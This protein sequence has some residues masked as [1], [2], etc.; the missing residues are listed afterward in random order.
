MLYF[1]LEGAIPPDVAEL[2]SYILFKKGEETKIK[3]NINGTKTAQAW[4]S[5]NLFR[6]HS[7]FK[8]TYVDISAF[9]R[10]CNF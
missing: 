6:G 5:F 4:E 3:P 1:C 10:Y 9:Y 8:L 2:L 7:G